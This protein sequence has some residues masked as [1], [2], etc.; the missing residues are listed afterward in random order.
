MVVVVCVLLAVLAGFGLIGH[1]RGGRGGPPAD[2]ESNWSK[3]PRA[4]PAIENAVYE[5][6]AAAL[7]AAAA[8]APAVYQGTSPEPRPLSRIRGSVLGPTTIP[9][10][11]APEEI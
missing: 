7:G 6:G 4:V 2:T 9:G 3:Q 11:A 5:T 1:R 10:G 8:R